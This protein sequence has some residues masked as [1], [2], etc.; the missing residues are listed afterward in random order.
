MVARLHEPGASE[1]REEIR[2]LIRARP[3]GTQ[4][5]LGELLRKSGH[6]VTQATLSR[7]L[8]RIGARRATRPDGGATYELAEDSL[9]AAFESFRAVRELIDWVMDNG[10]LVVVRTR[11]GA[12]SAVARVIDLARLPEAAGSIAGDDTI[13]VAPTRGSR[14][15]ALCRKLDRLFRSRA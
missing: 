1:R 15:A 13:F 6:Q 8:A 3:I 5:E 2:R 9:P 14:S 12:A 7:D 10:T 4:E 11:P